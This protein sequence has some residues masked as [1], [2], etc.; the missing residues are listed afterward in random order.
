MHSQFYCGDIIH[1]DTHLHLTNCTQNILITSLVEDGHDGSIIKGIIETTG[2]IIIKPGHSLVR[3]LPENVQAKVREARTHTTK[4]GKI[5]NVGAKSANNK[6]TIYPNAIANFLHIRSASSKMVGYKISDFY[7]NTLKK[8]T[9]ALTNKITLPVV[10]LK[11][12]MYLLNIQ[13]ENGTQHIKT[14]IKN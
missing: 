6:I 5:G 1:G 3:I 2:S 12:G 13:L 4:I 14:I 8:E 10:D 7:G 11:K 9:L